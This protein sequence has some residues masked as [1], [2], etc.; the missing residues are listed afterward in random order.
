MPRNT[1]WVPN[2]VLSVTIVRQQINILFVIWITH[3]KYKNQKQNFVTWF[4]STRNT[5]RPVAVPP[6][7]MWNPYCWSHWW[8]HSPLGSKTFKSALP[9]VAGVESKNIFSGLL[10]KISREAPLPSVLAPCILAKGDTTLYTS[11]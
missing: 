6:L 7:I 2:L 8:K 11:L 1:L 10:V 3:P 4:G 5:K 9:K